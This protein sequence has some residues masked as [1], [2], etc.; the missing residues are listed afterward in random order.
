M[1]SSLVIP[2][3]LRSMNA[4]WNGY[5]DRLAGT[6]MARSSTGSSRRFLSEMIVWTRCCHMARLANRNASAAFSSSSKQRQPGLDPPEGLPAPLQGG[7]A[8][9]LVRGHVGLLEVGL[10]VLDPRRV[11]GEQGPQ[12]RRQFGGG[13]LAQLLHVHDQPGQPGPVGDGRRRGAGH[14]VG[15]DHHGREPVGLVADAR[16]GSRRGG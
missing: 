13:R 16:R 12:L 3:R 11:G 5:H 15:G 4:N 6:S 14:L 1:W 2:G 8:R 7:L 10:P 9:R